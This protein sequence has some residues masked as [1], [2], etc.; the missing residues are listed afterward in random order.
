MHIEPTSLIS[1][2]VDIEQIKVPF[3]VYQKL[4]LK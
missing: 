1:H 4:K 2:D 3:S